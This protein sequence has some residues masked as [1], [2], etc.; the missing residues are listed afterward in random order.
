LLVQ[1]KLYNKSKVERGRAHR[2]SYE[3]LKDEI[4]KSRAAYEKGYG[5][6][7]AGANSYFDQ[8]ILRNLADNDRSLLG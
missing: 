5:S 3:R 4:D 6:T 7:A 1:I 8:E 2:N